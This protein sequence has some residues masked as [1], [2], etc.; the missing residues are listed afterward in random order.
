MN[1]EADQLTALMLAQVLEQLGYAAVSFPAG[2]SL[3]DLLAVNPSPADIIITSAVPPFAFAHSK[4]IHKQLRSRLPSAR[5]VTG[6]WGFSGDTEKAKSCFE[7]QQP[8]TI[9]TTLAEAAKY[10]AATS[11][12]H[13]IAG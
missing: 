3:R 6:V 12:G 9:L 5:T 13:R 8:A 7:R 2:A 4:A 10:I 1:D 11:D